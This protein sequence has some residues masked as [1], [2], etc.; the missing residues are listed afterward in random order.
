MFPTVSH[1]NGAS[2]ASRIHNG[3]H[4]VSTEEAAGQTPNDVGVMPDTQTLTPDVGIPSFSLTEATSTTSEI[5]TIDTDSVT[6]YWTLADDSVLY[7]T[8]TSFVHLKNGTATAFD[9]PTFDILDAVTLE[10]QIII[11]DGELVYVLVEGSFET[12]PL[13]TIFSAPIRLKAID[14]T[15]FWLSDRTG[16]FRWRD[17]AVLRMETSVRFT[18]PSLA[19]S[20][21]RAGTDE[22]LVWQGLTADHLR[23]RDNILEETTYA[24]ATYP[25]QVA[26][27]QQ[28]VWS[29]DEQRLFLLDESG[30]WQLPTYPIA[31]W[32]YTHTVSPRHSTSRRKTPC[33]T[34]I[35]SNSLPA[36]RSQ[37]GRHSMSSQMVVYWDWMKVPYFASPLH[38]R[39]IL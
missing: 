4:E 3:V 26:L 14:S 16:L 1:T 12:S 6:S 24:F 19:W 10:E 15:S 27:N 18:D 20:R 30:T 7:T 9:K 11:T 29:L 34:S 8:D 35:P 36:R 38:F 25:L 2:T 5:V 37:I 21:R 33:C 13:S 32:V 39:S 17:S 22:I 28:G 23:V 31:L